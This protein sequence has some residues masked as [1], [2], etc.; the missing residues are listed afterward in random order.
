LE[1]QL[2]EQS[3]LLRRCLEGHALLRKKLADEKAVRTPTSSTRPHA[4]NV[5]FHQPSSL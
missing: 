4:E 3:S 2:E 1:L 5:Y